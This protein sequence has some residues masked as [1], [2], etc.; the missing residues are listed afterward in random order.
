LP[1]K[2]NKKIALELVDELMNELFGI[3]FLE[4]RAFPTVLPRIK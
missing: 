2:E 1:I 3:H 4:A